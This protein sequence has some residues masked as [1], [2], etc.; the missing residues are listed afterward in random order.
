VL[1]IARPYLSVDPNDPMKF[2]QNA[3]TPQDDYLQ[4]ALFAAAIYLVVRLLQATQ[5]LN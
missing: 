1:D 4:L 5:G 3:N 2:F